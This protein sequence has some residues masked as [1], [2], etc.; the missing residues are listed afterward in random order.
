MRNPHFGFSLAELLVTMT[1]VGLLAS[2]AL[3]SYRHSMLRVQRSE[4]KAE[5]LQTSAELER[6]FL[7]F[8]SYT[9]ADCVARNTLPHALASGHYLILAATVAADRYTLHAVPQG[10]QA[11]DRDCRTLTL[12]SSNARGVTGGAD[13]SAAYCWSR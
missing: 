13:K 8:N 10:A 12:D 3:P 6:C 5:L 9:S 7:R 4:A 11:E 2:V 1:I